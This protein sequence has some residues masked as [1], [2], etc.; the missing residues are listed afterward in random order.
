MVVHTCNPSTTEAEVINLR[1]AW[2]TQQD[3][4]SKNHQH[5]KTHKLHFLSLHL[6]SYIDLKGCSLEQDKNLNL[7]VTCHPVFCKRS[8]PYRGGKQQGK[9]VTAQCLGKKILKIK[10]KRVQFLLRIYHFPPIFLGKHNLP[11]TGEPWVNTGPGVCPHGTRIF[12]Q[13]I[14]LSFVLSNLL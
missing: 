7:F 13:C 12:H 10:K 6:H 11:G 8:V 14:S 4:M 2:T 9:A 1:P 3:P 5:R